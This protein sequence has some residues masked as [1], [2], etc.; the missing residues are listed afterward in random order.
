MR[1]I[2]DARTYVYCYI[3][4]VQV[5]MVITRSMA[6]KNKVSAEHLPKTDHRV[7]VTDLDSWL[8]QHPS[9]DWDQLAIMREWDM[10]FE[11]SHQDLLR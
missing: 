5:I 10:T 4:V 3:L 2:L 6:A 7:E 1:V 11:P 8:S 9:F